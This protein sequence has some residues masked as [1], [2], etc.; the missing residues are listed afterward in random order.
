MIKMDVTR[1][2]RYPLSTEK[3]LRLL[4]KNSMVFVVDMN[5]TKNDVKR[6][7]ETLYEAKVVSVRLL[8]DPK[9]NKKAYVDFGEDTPAMDVATKLGIM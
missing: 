2:I 4:D 8:I 7:I 3:S 1:V 5:A 9:G 6:A